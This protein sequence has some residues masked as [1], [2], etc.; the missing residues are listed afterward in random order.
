MLVFVLAYAAQIVQ[1]FYNLLFYDARGC[2]FCVPA[3][4][5]YLYAGKPPFSLEWWNRGWAIEILAIV[6][7]LLYLIWAKLV[8]TAPGARRTFL[9][10]RSGSPLEWSS[11][12]SSST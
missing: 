12:S 6:P 4:R 2:S 11:R 10:L 7:I 3:E 5:S 8:R 1:N 9:P